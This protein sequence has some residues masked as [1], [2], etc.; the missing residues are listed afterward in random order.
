MIGVSRVGK[1]EL[2]KQ[3]SKSSARTSGT[4]SR[5]TFW[6]QLILHV[7]ADG[8][9]RDFPYL[10]AES[11]SVRLSRLDRELAIVDPV[12]RALAVAMG[13]EYSF[14]DDWIPDTPESEPF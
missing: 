6:W 3:V 10:V 7:T 11:S 14:S 8:G 2:R 1:V 5:P 4:Y 12:G 13:V 9:E